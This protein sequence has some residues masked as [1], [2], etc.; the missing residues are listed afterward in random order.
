MTSE[1]MYQRQ[2]LETLDGVSP[3]EFRARF[4]EQAKYAIDTIRFD[5]LRVVTGAAI[6]LTDKSLFSIPVNGAATTADGGTAYKKDK[7]DT[8]MKQPNEMEYGNILIVES[9]QVEAMIPSAIGTTI[10]AGRTTGPTAVAGATISPSLHLL[11]LLRDAWVEM[12]VGDR[13]VAEGR[14]VEFPQAG[15]IFGFGGGVEDGIGQNGPGFAR[16]L[17]E[18]VILRPGEQ[19]SVTYTP[20]TNVTPIIDVNLVFK[21]AGVRLRP[22]G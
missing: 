8:N 22:V 17:R 14:P 2:W 19:F 6:G 15:G 10:T 11:P 5:T 16:L 21:L 20:F 3:E 13:T 4:K 7:A 1:Q 9:L 18:V 12:R